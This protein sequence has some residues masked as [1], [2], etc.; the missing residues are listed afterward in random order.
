MADQTD[1]LL[2][3]EAE[4]VGTALAALGL[5]LLVVSGGLVARIAF[6]HVGR[7][8]AGI[9]R[10]LLRAP[11]LAAV[12]LHDIAG[13]ADADVRPQAASVLRTTGAN[14]LA[15]GVL[16]RIPYLALAHPW[17]HALA[18]AATRCLADGRALGLGNRLVSF[19]ADAH[20]RLL[21]ASVRPTCRL[22]DW[23]TGGAT[24]WHGIAGQALARARPR[25]ETV[26]SASGGAH[27]NA[28]VA[29]SI[30]LV[31]NL[32]AA[33]IGAFAYLV[34]AATLRAQRLAVGFAVALPAVTLIWSCAEAVCRTI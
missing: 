34:L 3:R 9:V 21:A 20:V 4:S 23:L 19:H 1:A 31:A 10:A 7:H 11:R 17:P 30:A 2:G 14:G 33:L 22:A 15:A 5:A 12:T 13:I 27:G 26:V 25:A 6:A 18:V 24:F 16:G 28:A 32:A 29:G 8:A